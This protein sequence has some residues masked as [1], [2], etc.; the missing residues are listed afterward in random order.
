MLGDLDTCQGDSTRDLHE[1]DVDAKY[2][3]ILEITLVRYRQ[4]QPNGKSN[5]VHEFIK[6][7]AK[8]NTRNT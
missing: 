7:S 4:R 1:V 5:P 2:L 6:K 8:S 3:I